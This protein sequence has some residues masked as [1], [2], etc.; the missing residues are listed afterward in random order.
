M[1]ILLQSEERGVVGC[2]IPVVFRLRSS[3]TADQQRSEHRRGDP[4][5][6]QSRV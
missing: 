5:P 2:A 6:D 4:E 1:G 3:M